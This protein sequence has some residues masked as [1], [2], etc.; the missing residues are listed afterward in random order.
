MR[1]KIN[2]KIMYIYPF[3]FEVGRKVRGCLAFQPIDKETKSLKADETWRRPQIHE[4][5][6]LI[7]TGQWYLEVQ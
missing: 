5:A 6:K 1:D 4:R 3:K 7:L 2:H